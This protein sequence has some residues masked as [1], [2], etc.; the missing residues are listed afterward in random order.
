MSSIQDGRFELTNGITIDLGSWSSLVN[1][2]RG[3]AS[4]I[5]EIRCLGSDVIDT[6][7]CT[8]NFRLPYYQI[9]LRY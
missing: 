4:E 6:K 2:Y 9:R 1:H 3:A 5:T 7:L 8:L